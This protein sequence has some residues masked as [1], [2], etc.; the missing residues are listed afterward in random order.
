M[1]DID[2]TLT[3]D[4]EVE[5]AYKPINYDLLEKCRYYKSLGFE[6]V[7]FTSRN[8]RTHNGNI[9]KIN[10]HTLPVIIEWLE[11][12]DVPYDEIHVGKPWCGFEGFYVDD[13]AIRP[14]E[15]CSLTY[16]EIID[17]LKKENPFND[18]GNK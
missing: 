5:Y 9:G 6:I 14:S 13:K 7:L 3:V 17:L 18:G 2:G 16:D 11:K 12:N 15:F 1:I 8:M 10:V 4:S